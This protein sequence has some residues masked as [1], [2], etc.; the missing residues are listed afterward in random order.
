MSELNT[1]NKVAFQLKGGMYTLTTIQ[2]LTTDIEEISC[3]LNDKI[4]QAP[5]FFG[6]APIV[7][8]LKKLNETEEIICLKSLT[9][10][11]KTAK[12]VP[13]GIKY[14]TQEQQQQAIELGVAILRDNTD[15][16]KKI[17]KNATEEIQT[18]IKPNTNQPAAQ[19]KII[20]TP[21]RSGQQIYAPDG[22]LIVT[23]HVGHGAEL[24][25][26]GNIH[27]YGTLR[28]RASAGINGNIDARIFCKS[29]EAELV[30]IAGEYQISEEIEKIAWQTPAQ[31]Y[32]K[33]GR[34]QIIQ[35]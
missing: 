16:I 17:S 14:P 21:V 30:S 23:S 6:N 24:L 20:T 29:L 13:V 27:V 12:L 5:N 11:L 26:N 33:E 1:A 18:N 4:N 32:F 15:T 2:P 22:D 34:L 9:E 28:G 19:T 31:I 10:K 7:I 35:L 3:A 8:D 25:A